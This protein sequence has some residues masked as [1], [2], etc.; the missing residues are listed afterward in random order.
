MCSLF[1]RCAHGDP[2]HMLHPPDHHDVCKTGRNLEK[3]EMD[4]G[5][6]G[7]TLLINKFCRDLLWQVGQED[8]ESTSVTPLLGYAI[9]RPHN[10]IIDLLRPNPCPFDHLRKELGQKF[11]SP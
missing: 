8:R 9:S 7:P 4:A 11:I 5:H 3:T 2:G 10:K 1:G 6:T